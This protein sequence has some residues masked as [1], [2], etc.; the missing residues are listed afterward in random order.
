M[1]NDNKT[2]KGLAVALSLS[3]AIMAGAPSAFAQATWNGSN[4]TAGG[5]AY[6]IGSGTTPPN[7]ANGIFFRY[8]TNSGTALLDNTYSIQ[9]M[10]WGGESW[11]NGTS[12]LTYLISNS[13]ASNYAIV[14]PGN[15]YNDG[16]TS[17]VRLLPTRYT[18]DS[19]LALNTDLYLNNGKVLFANNT[20]P[21]SNIS[22]Q[23]GDAT[24]R[25]AI[26]GLQTSDSNT[27]TE[28]QI[29]GPGGGTVNDYIMDGTGQ[30]SFTG[31][32]ALS[33]RMIS[34]NTWALTG[35]N[36]YSGST[37][38]SGGG[39][40]MLDNRGLNAQKISA[41]TLVLGGVIWTGG[42]T[43]GGGGNLLFIG[44]DTAASS[45]TVATLRV[46]LGGNTLTVN[47]GA[48]QTAV[49]DTGTIT[50]TAGATVDFAVNSGASIT[51]GNADGDLGA[52]ATFGG[53]D[54]ATVSG[55]VI[56]ATTY[57]GWGAGNVN[58]STDESQSDVTA[59][60]LKFGAPVTLT[61][62][63]NNTL[64]D[65]GIL[66]AANAGAGAA[67]ISGGVLT[68][69]G[70]ELVISQHNTQGAL[71][72]GSTLTAATLTKTGAGLVNVSGT[73]NATTVNL[74]GGV[75]RLGADNAL[76]ADATVHL[77]TGGAEL[78]LNGHALTVR[79]LDSY[80]I[81]SG[82]AALAAGVSTV[83]AN[84]AAGTAATLTV[85]PTVAMTFMG[86]LVEADGAVLNIV[87][88][89]G[90]N[91][92]VGGNIS[93]NFYGGYESKG[94]GYD[95]QVGMY[96]LLAGSLTVNGGYLVTTKD[97]YLYGGVNLTGGNW[98]V[99]RVTNL[100]ATR[101]TG[102]GLLQGGSPG[103]FFLNLAGSSE[104][105]VFDGRNNST[106]LIVNGA[107]KLILTQ[108]QTDVNFRG[109]FALGTTEVDLSAITTSKG[110]GYWDYWIAPVN[111][112]GQGVIKLTGTSGVI[113][114]VGGDSNDALTGLN[115]AGG[116][117]WIAP[118]GSG[119]DVT[120]SGMTAANVQLTYGGYGVVYNAELNGNG[121]LLLDQ[122]ANNSLDFQIGNAASTIAALSRYNRGTLVVA[123]AGGL[124][125]LGTTEKLTVLGA[126]SALPV[127]TN[128][129]VNT[130]IIGADG[131]TGAGSFLTTATVSGGVVLQE[132]VYSNDLTAA[133]GTSVVKVSA[134][135]TLSANTT[136]YALRNDSVIANSAT[137]T[138][139]TSVTNNQA[140]LVMNNASITGAG[141]IT[142]AT[143]TET[144]A[145][146]MLY[147][148]GSNL[149]ENKFA[150]GPYLTPALTLFGDG[151][152]HLSSAQS[153][154]G[155]VTLNS[156][157]LEIDNFQ[158]NWNSYSTIMLQGGVLQTSGSLTRS[159]GSSVNN[160]T[161]VWYSGGFAASTEGGLIVNAFNDKRTLS[162]YRGNNPFLHD[163]GVLV[164]GSKTAKG[165]VTL[166]NG[167]DL[168]YTNG[169]DSGGTFINSNYLE[170]NGAT[171]WRNIQVVDNPDTDYDY[172]TI[173]GVISGTASDYKGIS[174]T[175]DGLLKLT[176]V[177]TYAGPTSIAEGTLVIVD[178][179][180]LGA[181]PS[182]AAPITG[183]V[184]QGTVLINGGA[185]LLMSGG[186]ISANRNIL[187]ASGSN[188]SRGANIAVYPD[189][190]VTFGGKLGDSVGEQGSLL[191]NGTNIG[192]YRDP[193]TLAAV[194]GTLR[195]TGTSTIS[196]FTEVVQG[197]LLVDGG[198]TTAHVVIDTGAK[199]GGSGLLTTST[200]GISVSGILDAT[201]DLMLSLAAEQK[202]DFAIDSVLLVGADTL[203]FASVGDWLSG[204]GNAT[205]NVSGI[206]DY[207][208][209]YTIF[210]NVTTSGFTF[211]NISGYDDANF[212]AQWDS[213]SYI[214]SF[215]VIPE[216][217][218][219]ALIVT[220]VALLAILRRRR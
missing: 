107:G 167:I 97:L 209:S 120:V 13:N 7:V 125:G 174:K 207:S 52:W 196:G 16:A 10:T 19:M 62:T 67:A 45:Q 95:P 175:G 172:A 101:L 142:I 106:A 73:S 103:G 117:V 88:N 94:T 219:W 15:A 199:L 202:L 29:Y 86:D 9:A 40:L 132:A 162:W 178:D 100:A 66:F 49:F 74:A 197:T 177:N 161:F 201:D 18:H 37:T 47:A 46:D 179:S 208:T 193:D 127:L 155:Y 25:A 159:L 68:A 69:G 190:T 63:G 90:V 189:M 112:A 144:A 128:G 164:F 182:A 150:L 96:N 28:M 195:L 218:T 54:F 99:S 215:E 33:L 50:R 111:V 61:L 122:G 191:V 185:T 206:S 78:D 220:G 56:G 41:T 160:N 53:N 148:S 27:V 116:K 156:G 137:L 114:G 92:T 93:L 147:V 70:G 85:N 216:P 57:A 166:L 154:A 64:S 31:T 38:V 39:T 184:N 51:T 119:Q 145:E 82:Q 55:G 181:A 134:P 130:S 81:W 30:G 113:A 65:G 20:M 146:L 139:G 118:A 200:G 35:S 26:R 79:S 211:A 5:G 89:G 198:L 83:I 188:G 121:T 213:S 8:F 22:I 129:I 76:N 192:G 17:G 21:G 180:S 23:L 169:T 158:A 210:E 138:L 98:A 186:T 203:T 2:I 152:L 143:G 72:I 149:I 165:V 60:N 124:A 108:A 91:W 217:S 1:M 4:W 58:V 77:T 170:S 105:D 187:L 43:R 12:G 168:G 151:L 84:R 24:D 102:N 75:F 205:L 131:Q 133:T 104:A 14:F 42:D 115:M 123:A 59:K 80:D 110:Y 135:V 44:S 71:D 136:A 6:T 109:V 153:F 163:A 157:V 214:L 140:G 204:S 87:K 48:G 171:L 126:A 11:T 212:K 32:A 3:A 173:S 34:S 36:T 194:T 141:V 183:Y 176:G